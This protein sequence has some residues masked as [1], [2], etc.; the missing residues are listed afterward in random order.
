MKVAPHSQLLEHRVE[1]KFPK[2]RIEGG[3]KLLHK[4]SVA[5]DESVRPALQDIPIVFSSIQEHSFER[6][7]KA[8]TGNYWKEKVDTHRTNTKTFDYFSEG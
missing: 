2:R 7:M 6:R 1:I 8:L 5:I 3:L 4:F